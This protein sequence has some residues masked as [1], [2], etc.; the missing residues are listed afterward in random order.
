MAAPPSPIPD[1]KALLFVVTDVNNPTAQESLR[2][3][4][5]ETWGYTVTLIDDAD[6]QANYDAAVVVNDVAYVSSDIDATSLGVK[7][8]N[9]PIGILSEESNLDEEFGFGQ[10]GYVF[11]D[12]DEI[13]IRDNTHYITSPF[14]N[15]LLTITTSLQELHLITSTLGDGFQPLADAFN[16]GSLWDV[17]LGTIETG[18]DLFGGGTA[19]GRRVKLPW[20]GTGFDIAALNADGQTLM[21]RAIEWAAGAGDGSGGPVD[22]NFGYETQFADSEK[23]V[24]G[25]QVA[26]KVTLSEDG[27]LKSIT[28][29]INGKNNLSRAAVY[30]DSG[31][32]PGTLVVESA[33]ENEAATTWHAFTVPDTPLTAGTYWLAVS[34]T[35]KIQAYFYE[36]TGGQTRHVANDAVANGFLS[37]WGASSGSYPYQVSIYGT[38]TPS[39]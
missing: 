17:T 15:G 20:S 24:H 19:A 33:A 2:E 31:G 10:E 13:Q 32:E 9:A 22:T 7:L 35:D 23:S 37:N 28:A 25:Y 30:T 1:G 5:I 8:V 29:Y 39:Q 16:T 34:F 11:K 27:T 14:S 26:T 36:A 3:G 6:S 21:R 18:G 4:L 12:R 38:Y